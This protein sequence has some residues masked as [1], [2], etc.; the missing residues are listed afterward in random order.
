MIIILSSCLKNSKITEADKE[1]TKNIIINGVKVGSLIKEE[2]PNIK[3]VILLYPDY[4]TQSYTLIK[5]LSSM[6]NIQQETSLF[7]ED[8]P[9]GNNKKQLVNLITKQTPR[10]GFNEF[11]DLVSYLEKEG[12]EITNSTEVTDKTILILAPQSRYKKVL[13]KFK[14][15]FKTNEVLK[16]I[17]AGTTESKNIFDEINNLPSGKDISSIKV[18]ALNHDKLSKDFSIMIFMGAISEYRDIT[19]L[20][21]YTEDNFNLAPTEFLEENRSILKSLQIKKMNSVLPKQ[22]KTNNNIYGDRK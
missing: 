9:R 13:K 22:V 21:L 4:V 19:P 10:Y 3:A 20:K 5:F 15:S 8:Y 18:K 11:I 1:V 16:V 7:I 17:M 14:Y 2:L 6:L 12:I